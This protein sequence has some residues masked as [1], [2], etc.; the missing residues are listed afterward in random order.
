QADLTTLSASGMLRMTQGFSRIET[1]G[2]IAGAGLRVGSA[3][4]TTLA[5]AQRSGEGSLL[6]P[7]IAKVRTALQRE[8][9]DSSLAGRYLFRS[10]RDGWNLAI[11]EARIIGTSGKALLAVSRAQLGQSSSGVSLLAGNFST[12]GEG[13]PRIVGRMERA[14]GGQIAM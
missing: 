9:Q 1:E 8:G 3:L 10:G 5:A 12:G 13:L 6:E 2:E 14:E 7:L 4:D 11:P